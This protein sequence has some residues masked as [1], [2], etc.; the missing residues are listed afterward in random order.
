MSP[1]EWV[2]GLP[3]EL[4]TFIIAS[5]PISEL[6]GA[7]PIALGVY[8]LPVWSA[9]L[10]AILGNLAPIPVILT[11]L[12]PASNFLRQRSRLGDVFFQWLF[13]RT[14]RKGEPYLALY[15]DLGL[16]LFVA[17]PLPLTGAWTGAV[18]AF[19]FGLSPGRGLLLI[20]YG[21]LIAAGL[22]T[23]ASLGVRWLAFL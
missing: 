6:R 22:V 23:A 15:R 20:G 14:R 18:V 9:M 13:A 3:P 12:E 5:L 17:V 19:L 1:A 10:W 4:A 21:V 16:V 11:F 2:R 7:I 8:K